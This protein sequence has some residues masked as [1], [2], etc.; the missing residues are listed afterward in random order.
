[1][2]KNHFPRHLCA[3]AVSAA[4]MG[5]TTHSFAADETTAAE[6]QGRFRNN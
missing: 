3:V 2:A 6:E 4:L 1:M 5:F